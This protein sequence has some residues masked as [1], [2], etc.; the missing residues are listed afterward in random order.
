MT[1]SGRKKGGKN[2]EKTR[3]SKYNERKNLRKNCW[4]HYRE[5]KDVT[6]LTGKH[7][8]RGIRITTGT[9]NKGNPKNKG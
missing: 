9:L 6:G 7:A 4:S 1:R 8:V 5:K 3:I 2:G